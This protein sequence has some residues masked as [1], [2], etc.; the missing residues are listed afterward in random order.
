MKKVVVGFIC[1][2]FLSMLIYIMVHNDPPQSAKA[3]SVLKDYSYRYQTD[4]ALSVDLYLNKIDQPLKY[5]ESYQSLKLKS[6]DEKSLM[7]VTLKA[8]EKVR[9]E[10]YL[11]ETYVLYHL[12]LSLPKL[13]INYH[14]E[15]ACLEVELLN[16]ATYVFQ[17]GRMSIFYEPINESEGDWLKISSQK[18]EQIK[19]SRIHKIYIDMSEDVKTV[20]LVTINEFNDVIF[21]LVNHRLEITVPFENYLLNQF[22]LIVTYNDENEVFVISNH[23]FL[24][25][26]QILEK[27]GSL[28]K[29]YETN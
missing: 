1:F 5:K 27:S 7:S 13:D 9:E 28:I 21:N 29:I 6:N 24:T 25:D 18:D 2:V 22:T 23:E 15:D 19:I 10:T 8:I 11:N 3:I 16:G 20:D 17:I 26:Y 12:K 14:I 4:Q